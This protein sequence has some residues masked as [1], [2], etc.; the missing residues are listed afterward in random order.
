MSSYDVASS[1]HVMLHRDGGG[2]GD[3]GGAAPRVLSGGGG[4]GHRRRQQP[5]GGGLHSST[6]DSHEGFFCEI[7]WVVSAIS[8]SFSDKNG[9][10]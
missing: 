6:S 7:R 8:V 5:R 4:G 2:G 9:L 1:L 3:Q 10:G